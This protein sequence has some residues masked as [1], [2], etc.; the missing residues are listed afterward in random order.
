MMSNYT[1]AE[2]AKELGMAEWELL[3]YDQTLTA[4]SVLDDAELD[5]I[6]E[7]LAGEESGE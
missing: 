1:V 2:A 4:D 3:A 6:R 7:A 5:L